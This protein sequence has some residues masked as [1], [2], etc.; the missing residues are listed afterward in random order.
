MGVARGSW[1]PR[2]PNSVPNTKIIKEKTCK[3]LKLTAVISDHA[4]SVKIIIIL[5]EMPTFIL[6]CNSIVSVCFYPR[7]KNCDESNE[8]GL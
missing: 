7:S 5:C 1:D 4:W 8:H 2:T 6:V 3:L